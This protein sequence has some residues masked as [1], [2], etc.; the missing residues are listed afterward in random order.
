MKA[1]WKKKQILLGISNA[2]AHENRKRNIILE[3]AMAFSIM[4]LFLLLSIVNG[5][6]KAD[7]MKRIRENGVLATA[8][9]ENVSEAQYQDLEELSYVDEVGSIERFGIW[10]QDDH[11]AAVCSAVS[12]EDFERIF[13]PAYDNVTGRY[14]ENYNEVMLSVRVLNNLGIEEPQIGMEVPIHIVPYDW[15][16]TG[17]ENV[18]MIFQLSGYYTDY[19]EDVEKLPKVFFAKEYAQ[20]DFVHVI[21]D[22]VIISDKLWMNSAQ[23]EKQLSLDM[24]LKDEQNLF[25]MNEGASKTIRNMAGNVIFAIIGILLIIVSMNLFI[26]NIYS[27][28]V[29]K[30][31]QEYGLLKVIGAEPKQIREI[32]VYSELRI[33]L[34]GC[35][36]GII[37]GCL[38][39]KFILPQLLEKLYFAGYGKVSYEEFCSGKLLIVSMILCVTGEVFAMENCIRTVTKLPPIECS[40]YEEKI[41]VAC[42]HNKRSTGFGI[43]GIAWR[44]F[45]KNR[46]KMVVTIGSLFVG[47]EVFLLA[48]VISNGLDQTNRIMQEPDFEIGVTKEAVEYYLSLNEGNS[49]AEL[50]GHQMVSQEILA[51]IMKLAGI[52]SNTIKKCVGGFGTFNHKSE[53]MQPRIA[54]W[55]HDSEIITDLTVQVVPDKWIG[56]LETYVREKGYDTDLNILK[57]ENGFVL[58]HDHELSVNQ[59][60][61]ADAIIGQ[62]IE[63]TLFE[64]EGNTFELVCCGYLDFSQNGFPK[65]NMPWDGKN[66]NYII[67]SEKT[68][69]SIKMKP[70]IYHISFDVRGKEEQE[71]KNK[72]QGILRNANQN[73]EIMNTYYLTAASDIL[74][75]EQNYISGVRVMMGGFSGILLLFAFVSYYHTLFTGY[76][77]RKKELV[78]MRKIG[79][80]VRQLMK[81]LVY[82]GLYYCMFTSILVL[83]LGSGILFISGKIMH[84]Q[85]SYFT[86]QYPV[87]CVL[88]TLFVM[89]L[90][91]IFLPV[92][93]YS[94]GARTESLRISSSSRE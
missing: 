57:N 75:K 62:K 54:S 84:H 77:S 14:P 25:I 46:V 4:S 81:M 92:C 65:L 32:F 17:T 94:G 6:I 44:N 43:L 87:I 58:L 34:S 85:V 10:Y 12:K 29:N 19:I 15:L 93:L 18:D 64:E 82:E 48:V 1:A 66:L 70:E 37:L 72:L 35:I 52:N 20:Q 2:Y 63:V 30:K 22:G 47:I 79:M 69:D 51:E 21:K 60:A 76:V 88:G 59:T 50:R 8:I 13:L 78:I 9:L 45:T 3:T 24:I 73:S 71:I 49:L 83:T 80:T 11:Q 89:F 5:R 53:A 27:I 41:Y 55:Q 39:A 23:I 31:K 36:L 74:A 26:Y 16:K 42:I 68:M 33:L 67:I 61:E 86:Y 91:S 90:V 7:D 56:E 38:A 40:K 28:A